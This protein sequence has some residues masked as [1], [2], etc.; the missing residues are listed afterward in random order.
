MQGWAFHNHTARRTRC[1]PFLSLSPVSFLTGALLRTEGSFLGS[2]LTDLC[3][4]IEGVLR[5]PTTPAPPVVTALSSTLKH[6]VSVPGY[7]RRLQVNSYQFLFQ[8]FSDAFLPKVC[9]PFG[10]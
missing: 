10:L 1:V 9:D 7:V 4:K 2:I 3:A 5:S 8:Y 6:V